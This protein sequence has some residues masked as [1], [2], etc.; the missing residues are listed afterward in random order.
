MPTKIQGPWVSGIGGWWLMQRHNNMS[1]NA[2]A[3][4]VLLIDCGCY[5]TTTK[6]TPIFYCCYAAPQQ[7]EH[8]LRGHCELHPVVRDPVRPS[9]GTHPQSAVWQV[10]P[11]SPGKVL[12]KPNMSA[13]LNFKC[14]CHIILMHFYL[15]K[16]LNGR[17]STF[18][19]ILKGRGGSAA[20][21]GHVW[22][23]IQSA[24]NLVQLII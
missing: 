7:R 17:L 3:K 15:L 1:F 12:S 23:F 4:W 19:S 22:N 14:G 21:G 11:D 5:S 6:W 2:K 18:C 20:W 8:P 13:S 16:F 9:A 10:R 24:A